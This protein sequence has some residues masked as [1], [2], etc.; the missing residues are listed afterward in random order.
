MP[1]PARVMSTGTSSTM[2]RGDQAQMTETAMTE[3][4]LAKAINRIEKRLDWIEESLGRVVGLQYVPMGRSQTRPDAAGVPADVV[5]LAPAGKTV[6]AIT[7]YRE[8][9]G[10]DFA[11][12]RQ[13]IDNL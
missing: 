2:E 10:V 4:E 12:A 11:H 7:R 8:L 9:T 6:D 5:D 1:K 13:V 3:A